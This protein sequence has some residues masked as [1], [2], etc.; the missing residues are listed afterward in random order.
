[1]KKVFYVLSII[2]YIILFSIIYKNYST[3]NQEYYFKYQKIESIYIF[4]ILGIKIVTDILLKLK[5]N[6]PIFSKVSNTYLFV[7]ILSWLFFIPN[8]TNQN[9]QLSNN[10][11]AMLK[12]NQ[13]VFYKFNKNNNKLPSKEFFKSL[14]KLDLGISPYLKKGDKEYKYQVF[15]QEGD[16]PATKS[17]GFPPGSIFVIFSKKNN[18]FY[19]TTSI[20]DPISKK[21][22][23]LA[24]RGETIVLNK[25]INIDDIS[26]TKS[27]MNF[28]R[29]VYTNTRK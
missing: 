21:I 15:V 29:D 3:S 10:L 13:K 14:E 2:F 7:L 26:K 22:S 27:N 4:I 20:L 25:N 24:L 16:I 6:N 18:D 11:G 17:E 23:I 8:P 1:M 9:K 5:K 28:V 12:V 19:I